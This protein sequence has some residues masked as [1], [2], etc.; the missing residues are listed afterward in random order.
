MTTVKK[1]KSS[2][3]SKKTIAIVN[4]LEIKTDSIYKIEHKLD[5]TAPDGFIRAGATKLPSEGIANITH[6]RFVDRGQGKGM[7]DT[8]LE[9]NS[10]CY[11]GKSEAEK[12]EILKTLTSYIITPFESYKNMEGVLKHTNLDFWDNYGIELYE[13]RVFNTAEI[14]DL[15]DLYIALNSYDLT[16]EGQEGNPAFLRADFVIKDAEYAV[17]INEKRAMEVSNAIQG[18]M[19]TLNSERELTISVL[20][21]LNIIRLS[22]NPTDSS[23]ITTFNMWL[24]RDVQHPEIFNKVMDKLET[25]EGKEEVF[26]TVKVKKLIETRRIRREGTEYLYEGTPVGIDVKSIVSNLNTDG[27]LQEIKDKIRTS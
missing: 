17:S 26:L 18:F 14:T 6:C 24:T 13:G 7:Y 22:E 15:L 5:K 10:P 20:K 23:I 3:T 25:E 1:T 21:M 4:G 12:K 2:V 16:P 8:G 9:L 27:E 11:Q 19:N